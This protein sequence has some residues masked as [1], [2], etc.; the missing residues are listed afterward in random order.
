M[1]TMLLMLSTVPTV[2]AK[3]PEL[4][5]LLTF[6]LVSVTSLTAGVLEP[7]VAVGFPLAGFKLKP[8]TVIFSVI[9]QFIEYVPSEPRMTELLKPSPAAFSIP[10]IYGTTFTA[11]STLLEALSY[12][13]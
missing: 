7:I 1:S 3:A 2:T 5:A 11:N 9:E 13:R 12:K 4:A 6:M 10:V 8:F